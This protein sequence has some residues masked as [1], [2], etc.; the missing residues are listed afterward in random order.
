MSYEEGRKCK[1]KETLT[2]SFAFFSDGYI[3]KFTGTLCCL[4]GLHTCYRI[5]NVAC[6]YICLNKHAF[7]MF[8][9]TEFLLNLS[10]I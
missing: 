6:C 8:T 7:F 2:R 10:V 4:S 3:T 5:F 1:C 9:L